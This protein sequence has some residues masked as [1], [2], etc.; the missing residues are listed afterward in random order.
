MQFH[1]NVG[2]LTD[3]GFVVAWESYLQDGS[4]YGIYSNKFDKDGYTPVC[5]D[6]NLTKETV[7]S[8]M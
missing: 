4:G 3:G 7:Y 2:S 6:E 1:P 8:K 5:A